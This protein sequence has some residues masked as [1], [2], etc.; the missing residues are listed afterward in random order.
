MK[1][2]F[3][4]LVLTL[5]MV[6]SLVPATA[7]AM[8]GTD[9]GASQKVTR[10]NLTM[11]KT[12]TP[13]E[14]GTYTV[15][16]ESYATG[17]V[18]T[19][20]TP[21]PM[22]FVLVLDVSG[23][24]D[25]E[26]ASYTY[27]ATNKTSWSVSDVYDAYYDRGGWHRTDVTYYAKIGDE[28]YPVSY[29]QNWVSQGWFSGYYEYWLEANNEVLG[30]KVTDST[31]EETVYDQVL[32]T[33]QTDPNK[34]TK[35]L[36]AMKSA[37][38]NFI[39]SV[40]AQK[41]GDIPVAHR[42]S[43]VKFAG[44]LSDYVGNYTY[45]NG[46]N[47]YN[48]TQKVTE[49]TDVTAEG[50]VA[51]LKKAVNDLTAG[52][53]TAADWGMQKANDVL[54]KRE[55]KENP[56]I[57]IMFTDG[58]PNH[59]NGYEASVAGNTVQA[60]KGLKD[61]GTKVYTIGMFKDLQPSNADKVDTYMNGVSSNY[62]EAVKANNSSGVDLGTRVEG[63]NYYFKADNAS[64]LE[65][66][67]QTISES[68]TTTSPLDAS[69][70]VVDNVPSNFALNEDS[71]TVY[72]EDCTG[73]SG[74]ELT[75][76][77]T[78]DPV[79]SGITTTANKNAD[80][81]QTISTTGFNFSEHWCGLEGDTAHGQKL[82]IEFTISRTNYGG[83][84]PTNAGAY[85][86]A[87]EADEK[88]IISLENPEVPVTVQLPE[89]SDPYTDTKVYDGAGF[90]IKNEIDK[91]VDGLVPVDGIKNKFIDLTYEIK[92]S[93]GKTVG[94]YTILAGET[95]GTWSDNSTE[96]KTGS[97][98]GD[99][100]YKITVTGQDQN[101]DKPNN[102]ASK[103]CEATF[104]I[105][106]K[107][108]TFIGESKSVTWNGKEQTITG[109][110]A[111]TDLVTGHTYESGLAY[112]AKGT[113][114]G[115]YGGKF[116]GTAI[117]KDAAD[118]DVTAN[119]NVKTEPGTLTITN[120]TIDAN[121]IFKIVGGTWNDDNTAQNKTVKVTLTNGKGSLA[122][123]TIPTGSPSDGYAEPGVWT[124]DAGINGNPVNAT[125]ITKNTVFT[126]TYSEIKPEITNVD[127]TFKI[128]GGTWNGDNPT[129]EDKTVQVTLTNGKGSLD[130]VTIPTGVADADHQGDGT[131]SP[132][133]PEAETVITQDGN[134]V[135]TLTFQEKEKPKPS[136]PEKWDTSKSKTAT[137]LDSNY[138][139]KVTLSLPSAEENLATD[140]VLVLDASKCTKDMLEATI[141]LLGNLEKQV[142][143]GANIK[144]GIVMFKGN[145]VPFRTLTK[146]DDLKDLC[147]TFTG[148]IRED[149]TETKAAVREYVAQTYS[150]F[151]NGGTNVPS[152]LQLAKNMLEED[153]S[154]T[155]ARKYVVLVSDGDTYLFCHK[156]GENSGYDYTKAYTRAGPSER[157]IGGVSEY[158]NYDENV[159]VR[160]KYLATKNTLNKDSWND[161]LNYVGEHNENFAK[162]D[163]QASA[164]AFNTGKFPDGF[165][166]DLLIPQTVKDRIIN[167][168]VSRY[169]T[170]ELYSELQEKYNCYYCFLPGGYD[171]ARTMLKAFTPTDHLI[172][173]AGTNQDNIFSSITKD[174]VY[175][176]GT[177]STVK[178]EIGSGKDNK[179]NDYNF[180]FVDKAEAMTLTVGKTTYVTQKA[181]AA[182][183]T[184][185]ETSRYLFK[186]EGVVAAN[187]AEAPYVLHYYQKG[188]DGKSNECFVWD[189]NV[190]VS[191]FE[192]VQL[193]YTVKLTNPQS[194]KGT[195]YGVYDQSGE[196]Q[197]PNSSLYTNL[198]AT[199]K[200]VNS[201]GVKGADEAFLKPTVSYT[202]KGSSGGHSGGTVT[203]PDDVP[204]GLNGKDHYAYVVGYPDGMVYP[205]KNI[206]RAEVA[207]IFFR[208]LEDETREANMTKSNSYND[209]KDGAW[210]TCAVS[211]LSKMGIIKGYEDGSFKPDASISRAEFA[212][213]AARFDPDG[214]TTP[215]TF[216]D[217][218]S[219][220]AKDE[221]SIAANHGWIK[222]YEDGSFK[223]DQKITRA[224]TMTL[225]NRVLKRLP[226]TKDDLHKDMKTW[227]DNQ[228]ESAWFYL[229]VQEAT[230]SHYQKLKKDGIHEKWESMRET[231][232]W[233]ALEK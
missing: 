101:K 214:D 99:Y 209:M 67:F 113:D 52:G 120:S 163:F 62:P 45:R 98:V 124:N 116:T 53:A 6:L 59:G 63:S 205:Q 132:A 55:N 160:D 197:T 81:S 119:Y 107:E 145:A 190:N 34:T 202:I 111:P 219:H 31:W 183:L 154:V 135:F 128:V 169:Q 143:L 91:I 130:D 207:T 200:P 151:M 118:T 92:D 231:R 199:L 147:K 4:A 117:I 224:E 162:Y 76:S 125:E 96:I 184:K 74:E 182:A 232:D 156:N 64:D 93:S 61:G 181:E 97:N 3:L 73:K 15:R 102:R 11:T 94:T 172:D 114:T 71:V 70:V 115:S 104:T 215:A 82:I 90:D 33:R 148:L 75:W 218:S 180:D 157:Y 49:L 140:V 58:E 233:A 166:D 23:S 60:A 85:I 78:P 229:A 133:T 206:T 142:E 26:I 108:V 14:N 9:G 153:T 161:Y 30:H 47:T 51:S 173:A 178:D 201:N 13:N 127:V 19:T 50:S 10:D 43:I 141:K 185:H 68:T 203:I 105:T 146:A 1:K 191:N 155:D 79:N 38:N 136:D 5:A 167:S 32:Y 39:D 8:D 80:G 188:E 28:Y 2:K 171:Q 170:A 40:A 20:Q 137:N 165:T 131:W 196:K 17:S 220:W 88:T 226:E 138:E 21:V 54:T 208:L 41:N 84:Q 77:K 213:I 223:P 48:Y 87:K 195:T 227:P 159:P 65:Q 27:Q 152:G 225:V 18:T 22:D 89:G 12:V 177:G 149:D 83:T 194:Q 56:S 212:A 222:G 129:A 168:D 69:A 198:S 126:L 25:E 228:N 192:T 134:K 144:V 24:M 100:K 46:K 230:N 112:V 217:V 189:I 216:S 37:V 123:V 110:T 164:E 16:L 176:L 103:T 122:G 95:T 7:L 187:Q 29:K 109:I 106:Q 179:G 86:K 139:S 35:K 44:T 66:V 150:E 186:A 210:Y 36:D 211:T 42:I 193:T 174:I 175:L 72:T 158:E 204:T 57:V 121:V 221:I